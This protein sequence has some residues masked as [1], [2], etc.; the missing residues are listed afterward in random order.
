MKNLTILLIHLALSAVFFAA[1]L[2]QDVVT[3]TVYK[4]ITQVVTVNAPVPKPSPANPLPSPPPP[5]LSNEV[6]T[7]IPVQ[8]EQ[9]PAQIFTVP[10]VSPQTQQPHETPVVTYVYKTVEQTFT[11]VQPSPTEWQTVAPYSSYT[12]QTFT[13]LYTS[14]TPLTFVSDTMHAHTAS[15]FSTSRNGSVSSTVSTSFSSRRPSTT[16]SSTSK[17][18]TDTA[19][20]T[21]SAGTVNNSGVLL[22]VGAVLLGLFVRF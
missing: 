2:A 9:T 13:P 10:V 6:P 11:Q 14:A 18:A 19:T 8:S 7:L 3:I 4:T 16:G 1:T 22:A 20:P 15:A 17:V 5:N 12:A 21:E